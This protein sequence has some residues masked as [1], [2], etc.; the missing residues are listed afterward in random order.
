MMNEQIC[1]NNNPLYQSIN[2][3]LQT[4]N[5]MASD[6][7]RIEGWGDGRRMLDGRKNA[8]GLLVYYRNVAAY[9]WLCPKYATG[10]RL[11]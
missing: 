10:G 4:F 6:D 7:G 2:Q 11:M 1:F 8:V 9:F 3:Y 5:Y